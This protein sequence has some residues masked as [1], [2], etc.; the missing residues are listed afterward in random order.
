MG[1]EVNL[2]WSRETNTAIVDID[3]VIV[4]GIGAYDKLTFVWLVVVFVVLTV[5]LTVLLF[6]LFDGK[7]HSLFKI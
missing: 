7:T 2:I 1:I 4:K 6:V 5:S 3:I